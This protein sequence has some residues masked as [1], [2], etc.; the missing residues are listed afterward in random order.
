[1]T[2]PRMIPS[3]TLA[4]VEI[5]ARLRALG[6][7]PVGVT[8]RTHFR[9]RQQVWRD[10]SG[11]RVTLCEVHAI[12]ERHVVLEGDA[13]DG[14]TGALEV[15]SRADILHA[16]AVATGPYE[17]LPAVRRLCL[18]DYDA[19]SPELHGHL[20]RLLTAEDPFVRSAALAAAMNLVGEAVPWALELA[21]SAETDEA[22]RGDYERAAKRERA[23]LAAARRSAGARKPA[24]ARA[25]KRS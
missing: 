7:A 4:R 19:L 23:A 20:E 18:L 2:E 11:S 21:A 15:V 10:R 25:G 24:K 13:P 6:Y 12:G 14:L 8:P 9:Y 16:A 5:D 3:P 17:A 22:L 1:M